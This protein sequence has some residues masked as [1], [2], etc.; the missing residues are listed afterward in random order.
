M[1][2]PQLG[3][4]ALL[5]SCNQQHPASAIDPGLGHECYDIHSAAL[6]P[7]TRYGGIKNSLR[8]A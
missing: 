2:T 8:T 5:P 6:Q 7:G 1:A 4:A 3:M